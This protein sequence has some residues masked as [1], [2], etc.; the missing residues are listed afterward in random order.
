[1]IVERCFRRRGRETPPASVVSL[2]IAFSRSTRR[3]GSVARSVNRTARMVVK[4]TRDVIVLTVKGQMVKLRKAKYSP[5]QLGGIALDRQ[6]LGR[7]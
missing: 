3:R 1:M 2:L 6:S 7:Q 4:R 5:C